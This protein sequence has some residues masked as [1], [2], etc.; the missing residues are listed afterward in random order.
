VAVFSLVAVLAR[1]AWASA[2]ACLA[3]QHSVPSA[4]SQFF[5]N[6]PSTWYPCSSSR[7][8]ETEE[9]TPPDM[10]TMARVSAGGLACVFMSAD[11]IQ[12]VTRPVQIVQYALQHQGAAQS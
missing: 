2:R 5:M 10:P 12:W 7:A 6:N 11:Q 1:A 8:A 3:V 9:S 4:W